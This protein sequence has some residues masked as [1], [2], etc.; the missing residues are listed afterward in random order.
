MKNKKKKV[1]KF[2]K[3]LKLNLAA[4]EDVLILLSGERIA[5]VVEHRT[6]ERFKI[7]PSTTKV[8]Q[9]KVEKLK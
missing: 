9:V 7:I 8:L 3:D 5:W 2:F 1:S 6:D 4:K